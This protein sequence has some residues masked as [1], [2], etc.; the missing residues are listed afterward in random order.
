LKSKCGAVWYRQGRVV[1]ERSKWCIYL[2]LSLPF[3][4]DQTVVL[5]SGEVIKTRSRAHKSSAG[6]DITQLFIGAEGTLGI[7][8]E[9]TIKLTPR[10]PTTVA[11]AHFP[12]A[13]AAAAAVDELL[14]SQ[15]GMHIR[16][17]FLVNFTS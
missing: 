14:K 12:K 7:V 3:E 8:T 1:L 6:F 4:L 2:N 9:V 17:Y 13:D 16:Q 10:L 15:Y 5:P 11:V